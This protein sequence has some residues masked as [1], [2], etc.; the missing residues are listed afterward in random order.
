MSKSKISGNDA[1]LLKLEAERARLRA[2]VH[3]L[4]NKSSQLSRRLFGGSSVLPK[5]DRKNTLLY[6]VFVWGENGEIQLRDIKD[7]NQRTEAIVSPRLF[8]VGTP[9]HTE[10]LTQWRKRQQEGKQRIKWW[11]QAYSFNQAKWRKAGIPALDAREKSLDKR[12]WAI[13]D[14]I[15]QVPADGWIGIAVKLRLF[16]DEAVSQNLSIGQTEDELSAEYQPGVSAL[17]DVERL[18]AKCR[19]A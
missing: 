3:R 9:R 4:Q 14:K 18:A 15:P 11:K 12:I 7:F 16:R 19:A 6:G 17:H 8:P 5:F 13:E 1:K 2:E 10:L